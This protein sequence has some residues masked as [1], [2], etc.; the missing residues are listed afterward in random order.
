[1]VLLSIDP[2]L[3]QSGLAIF[4]DSQLQWAGTAECTDNERNS[5]GWQQM[6][7]EIATYVEAASTSGIFDRFDLVAHEGFQIRGR[8]GR[9][10]D[11]LQLAGVV[12]ASF[13]SIST[14]YLPDSYEDGYRYVKPQK[15]T[16]SRPKEANQQRI[17]RRLEGDEKNQFN[18]IS[19]V[20][21]ASRLFG[22]SFE[23]DKWE[24]A[25]DAVGIGLYCVRRL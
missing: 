2:G 17:W 24:H 23:P 1:M 14:Q 7:R 21:L 3:H 22:E 4:V 13:G 11:I 25:I 5:V 16:K 8:K 6:G 20:A 12:G 9:P 19:A 18:G 15:W 10:K